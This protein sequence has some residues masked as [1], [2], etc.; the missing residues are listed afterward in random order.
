[1]DDIAALAQP[2]ALAVGT[3]RRDRDAEEFKVV[4]LSWLHV[5]L[6]EGQHLK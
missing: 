6:G 1:M 2:E 5:K 3:K 4:P